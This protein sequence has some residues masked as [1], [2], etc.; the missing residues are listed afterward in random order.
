M[1]ENNLDLL[2]NWLF[3]I[4]LLNSNFLGMKKKLF[5]QLFMKH[6]SLFIPSYPKKRNLRR[7][8][9]LV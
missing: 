3:W 1:M 6:E 9:D 2:T 8:R 7:A 4:W 5:H